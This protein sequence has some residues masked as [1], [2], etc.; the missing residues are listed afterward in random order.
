[1]MRYSG[2]RR[3][4]NPSRKSTS[5]PPTLPKLL[6]QCGIG[7]SF[8]R[9][10]GSHLEEVLDETPS[11][12]AFG[13]ASSSA[14]ADCL[15]GRAWNPVPVAGVVPPALRRHLERRPCPKRNAVAADQRGAVDVG[16]TVGIGAGESAGHLAAAEHAVEARRLGGLVH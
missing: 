9:L 8:G 15:P 11:E 6:R 5:T 3:F 7:G 13:V 14:H 12:T 16:R 4:L 2:E 1:M 10:R